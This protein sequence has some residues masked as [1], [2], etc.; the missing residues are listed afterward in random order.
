[1][2]TTPKSAP[3]LASPRRSLV[4]TNESAR[5][6]FRASLPAHLFGPAAAQPRAWRMTRRDWRDM[7]GAYVASLLAVTLFIA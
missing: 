3:N 2:R 5:H 1:M 4:L 7:L 6:P